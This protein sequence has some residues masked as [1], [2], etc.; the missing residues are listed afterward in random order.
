MFALPRLFLNSKSLKLFALAVGLSSTAAV[1]LSNARAEQTRRP[2]AGP[3][4]QRVQ[5]LDPLTPEEVELATR[6]ATEDARVKQTLGPG[7][8]QVIRVELLAFKSSLHR[9][10]REPERL[11]IGRH[12]FVIFF[13]Y[14]NNFGL[15]VVVDLEKRSAG[16]I[17][18]MDGN[19]V[20][21]GVAEV[22]EAFNLALRNEGV[23]VLL[24]ANAGEFRVAG[25]AGGER[26]ENRV[27]GLRIV[28]ASPRDPCYRHR[29]VDLIFHRR[30]G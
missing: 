18:K 1:L 10:E 11:Q 16:E 12:A 15:H 2:P 21:L 27:E 13:S 8:Q 30:G 7:R 20:P 19:T 17:T 9:E 3:V 4:Q 5:S 24:G 28:T 22:T 26:P 29:C 6:I 23:R 25:L 14:D